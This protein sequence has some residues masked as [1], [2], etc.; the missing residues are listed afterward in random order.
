MSQL[1]VRQNLMSWIEKLE[2]GGDVE[3]QNF[4]KKRFLKRLR[5]SPVATDTDTANEQHYEVPTEFFTTVSIELLTWF[6][7]LP[8]K[9]TPSS[10]M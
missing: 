8:M 5:S 2:C 4:F 6:L 10:I 7:S 3:K 9:T 1:G